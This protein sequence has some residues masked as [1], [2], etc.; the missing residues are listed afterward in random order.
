MKTL[1][2]I[3]AY[4]ERRNI[5]R[6]IM[7]IKKVL[8]ESDILVIN[9]GSSDDTASRVADTGA[10]VV[11]HL[12]PLGD[13]A[14][15][16]TGFVYAVRNNYDRVIQMDGDGQHDPLYIPALL[17]AL[18]EGADVAIGSRFLGVQQGYRVPV[19][20]RIGML[21]FSAIASLAT[22]RR[23]TDPTSGFRAV[24]KD[25][26]LLYASELYPRHFP[27]ADLLILTHRAGFK[28]MEVPVKMH[29]DSGKSIHQG[30]KPVYYIFKMFLS[31][32]VTIM[33]KTPKWR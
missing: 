29:A 8:P 7:N 17:G 30:L 11:T 13:G 31:I 3:P 1:V 33:R 28:I 20:R 4:N 9:D 18:A 21:I 22:G 26:A 6:V 19:L 2:L 24:N 23:I 15:R 14:A 32:M 5:T 10:G 12:F 27:D 16:Q 25:A